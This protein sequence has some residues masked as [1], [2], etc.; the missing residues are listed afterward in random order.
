MQALIPTNPDALLTR[1]QA[2]AAL[3]E[4]GFPT[5]PATLATKATRGGGPPY[6]LFGAKPLYRWADAL[7]WARSRLSEP[8][9]STSEGAQSQRPTV[10]PRQRKAAP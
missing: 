8:R 5:A 9:H 7:A 2:A 4:V 10:R 6:R 1:D 3:T